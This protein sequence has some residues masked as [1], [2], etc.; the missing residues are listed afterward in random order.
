M[1]QWKC[2]GWWEQEGYGR[3]LMQSLQLRFQGQQLEGSGVDVV[4]AFTLTGVCENGRVVFNKQYVQ[5]HAVTYH[6]HYDGEGT[7]SGDWQ[8][9]WEKGKW[10]IKMERQRDASR[11]LEIVDFEP[12]G[13]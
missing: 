8:L 12:N 5:K 9:E 4:G 13:G 7:F 6:G 3:Q 11:P 10:L 1:S 2:R